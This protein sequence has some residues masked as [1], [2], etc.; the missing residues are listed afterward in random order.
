MERE[1]LQNELVCAIME[2]TK[3]QLIQY[4]DCLKKVGVIEYG[5]V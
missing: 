4:L 3:E 2:L 1:D 5:R